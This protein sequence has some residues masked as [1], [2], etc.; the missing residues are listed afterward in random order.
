M[1]RV[2]H[3]YNRYWVVS[4]HNLHHRPWRWWYPVDWLRMVAYRLNQRMH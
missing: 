3:F 4:D 2:V 1:A